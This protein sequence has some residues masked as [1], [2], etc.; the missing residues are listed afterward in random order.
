MSKV[1]VRC[2]V[3]GKWFQSSNAKDTVCHDCTLKAK[4]EKLAKNS[5]TVTSTTAGPA[6]RPVP[7]APKPKPTQS[8]TNQWLDSLSDVKVGQ[9]ELPT[10]R[11]KLPTP[12]VQRETRGPGISESYREER[13][14]RGPGSYREDRGEQ[15]ERGPAGYR[16]SRGPGSYRERE[17][18]GRGPGAYR[19]GVSYPGTFGSRPRTPMEGGLGRGPR[20]GGPG[21]SRFDRSRPGVPGMRGKPATPRPKV[22]TPKPPPAPRPKREKIPP[23]QPFQPTPEQV[24][25]V[26]ARYL[27]L[28]TPTEFDGIR[29]QIAQELGIPKAADKKIVK[30]LRERQHIPSWWEVQTYKGSS[31][32]LERIKELY[33]PLLPLP[34]VGIHK[35]IAEQ[36]SLKPAMVYQAIKQIRLDMNLPQYNDPSLHGLPNK[37]AGEEQPAAQATEATAETPTGEPTTAA[38]TE[39]V[40]TPET[41]ISTTDSEGTRTAKAASPADNEKAPTAEPAEVLPESIT[42]ADITTT[43]A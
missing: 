13:G 1:K 30:E 4:K 34:E 23:P 20:P 3:C 6:S 11:P 2:T 26:E 38:T 35:K 16:D 42:V 8:G 25:Q 29:T 28:A 18:S 12:P 32:D 24:A 36:L 37:Q 27:E 33:V 21:D 43:E 22:K 40:A 39:A 19:P 5:P 7:P 41:A 15:R 14:D 17:G 10:A 9:P 31:E